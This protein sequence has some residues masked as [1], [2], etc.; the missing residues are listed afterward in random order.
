MRGRASPPKSRPR[1]GEGGS[2]PAGSRVCPSPQCGTRWETF[3]LLFLIYF[4]LR[5]KL[6]SPRYLG[7]GGSNRQH[8]WGQLSPH[9]TWLSEAVGAH[10]LTGV[11]SLAVEQCW[12]NSLLVLFPFYLLPSTLARS[13]LEL[14]GR[15]SCSPMFPL[16]QHTF[17]SLLLP[18][19][20]LGLFQWIHPQ[21]LS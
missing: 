1:W 20:L 9:Q 7:G 17:L 10:S 16:G 12:K 13:P 6:I 15:P 2:H 5:H 4:Y 19:A 8:R 14:R 3:L 11:R 21:K 18:E